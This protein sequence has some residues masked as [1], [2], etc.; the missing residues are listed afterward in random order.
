[1]KRGSTLI[2]KVQGALIKRKKDACD[3]GKKGHLSETKMALITK[4]KG[5]LSKKMGT[6]KIYIGAIIR[7][8]STFQK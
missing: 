8:K 5:H 4:V 2:K 3:K 1:M 7:D 6:S